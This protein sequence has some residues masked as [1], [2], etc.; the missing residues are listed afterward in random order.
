VPQASAGEGGWFA[1]VKCIGASRDPGKDCP[2]IRSRPES[3]IDS[4]PLATH[5]QPSDLSKWLVTLLA[6]RMFCRAPSG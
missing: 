2:A 5:L 1:P 4:L 3:F 6:L